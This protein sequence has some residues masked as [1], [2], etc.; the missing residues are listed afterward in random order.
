MS[1]QVELV[2]IRP[3]HEKAILHQMTKTSTSPNF[4]ASTT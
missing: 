4:Q 2:S 3:V 1:F